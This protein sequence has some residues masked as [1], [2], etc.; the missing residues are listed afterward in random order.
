MCQIKIFLGQSQSKLPLDLSLVL[1]PF[2]TDVEYIQ[3]S[4]NGPNAVDFHIAFYIGQLAQAH[5]DA[6]FTIVS[7]DTGFDPLVKHL[8]SLEISCKRIAA[9]ATTGKA[10]IT[11][12]AA[13]KPTKP[14]VKKSVVAK[15]KPAKNVVVTV[16]RE[17][18]G[19]N[20]KPKIISETAS[21]RVSEVIARL[22]GLKA[23]K[24]AKL[25]TLLSSVQS[26]FKP[27]LDNKQLAAVIQSLADAKKIS[28]EGTKVNYSL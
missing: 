3:I 24:P 1:Q 2:G 12:Q 7:K 4:G 22:K 18:N 5:P 23:A 25:T 26:W 28:V 17:T 6:S 15:A 20:V 10:T 8:A 21:A 13:T 11:P 9:I 16:V 14:G 27:P 19:F